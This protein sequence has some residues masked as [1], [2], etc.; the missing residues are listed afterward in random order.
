KTVTV[1]STPPVTQPTATTER[2]ATTSTATA[3][4]PSQQTGEGGA[5][6]SSTTRT[7]PEP[8]FTEHDEANDAA[9][10]VKGAA[11]ALRARGYTPND[12]SEYHGDQPL[13]VLI[14]TRTGSADGYGQQ[15]FFFVG[16]R[17]IGTDAKE[18]SAK[19]KVVS[20]SETEVTLAY[21]LYRKND[22]LC[23]P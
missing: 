7:A 5:S 8:A 17:Y 12:T 2:P 23:C 20:Q 11:A 13:R 19:V 1:S 10:G 6:T 9:A 14:G 18:P 21:P 3:T 22:P 15:A 16:D 4:S